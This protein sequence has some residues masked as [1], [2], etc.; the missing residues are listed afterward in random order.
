LDKVFAFYAPNTCMAIK[1]KTGE[2]PINAINNLFFDFLKTTYKING[3][4]KNKIVYSAKAI[5]SPKW[6]K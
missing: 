6:V 2:N 5:Q 3:K 1:N 4:I